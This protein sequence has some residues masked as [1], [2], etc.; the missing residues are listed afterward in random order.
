MLTRG[1]I[2]QM[3]NNNASIKPRLQILDIKKI[4]TKEQGTRFRLVLSDG[5]FYMQ[6]MMSSQMQHLVDNGSMQ[7]F[8]VIHITEFVCNTIK[9][10]KICVIINADVVEQRQQGIGKPRNATSAPSGVSGGMNHNQH[11]NRPAPPQN[12]QSS[13]NQQRNNNQGSSNTYSNNRGGGYGGSN[14]GNNNRGGYGG[15]MNRG[16]GG[17]SSNANIQPVSS[18]NPY[19]SGWKIKV[20]CTKKDNMR[21]Y[22]NQ[23]GDGKL[24]G[25]DFLDAEGTEIRAVCFNEAADKFFPV[26]EKDCV[27]LIS[28]GQVRLARKGFSH[29]TN[30]YSITLNADSEVVQVHDA[31]SE[32]MGTKYKFVEIANIEQIE[33]RQFVDV[34]GVVVD[35]GAM[36]TI[37]S[38]KTQRE[39]KR[40]NLKLADRTAKID[41][42]LW[43]QD[44]E[45]FDESKLQHNAIVAFKGCKVSDFGGRSLSASGL[46]AINP[47]RPEATQLLQWLNNQGGSV[48]AVRELSSGQGGG[49]PAPR[50]TFAEA[51]SLKLGETAPSMGG[52]GKPDYFSTVATITSISQSD[53]KRPW[54]EA[55]PDENATEAKNAKVT[56]MGDGKWRCEKNGKVY[57]GYTPR[58]ILRFCAT[59]FT[60]NIWLTAFNESAE[61]LL[62][63]PA[64]EAERLLAEDHEAYQ[65]LFKDIQFKKFVFKIK[66]KADVWEDQQRVRYDCIG[67]EPA[68]PAQEAE[69]LM[70][71]IEKL[72]MA[73]GGHGGQGNVG[74]VGG[75]GN[76]W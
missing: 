20:R 5:D 69:V 63:C 60:G 64:T 22:H 16:G 40:R 2:Q 59:D 49:A 61:K 72:K 55:N 29:I 3:V 70:E 34:I 56:P 62:G 57:S 68:N 30:D 44:A 67:V 6:G 25:M 28:R 43:N 74:H 18:L 37:M 35:V 41:V 45:D 75:G 26:I 46:I 17:A 58:Y 8:T 39:M 21:H 7:K 4:V 32:I 73:A 13:W 9:N 66:A 12:Q 23:K 36:T 65:K 51:K 10:K 71:K 19:Q 38:Q 15:G 24:F 52:S 76:A 31:Q 48:G 54:Y 50:R 27:Y 33:P 1:A 42:T 47:D 53:D 11:Q 14:T